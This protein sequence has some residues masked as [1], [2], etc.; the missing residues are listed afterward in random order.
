MNIDVAPDAESL[1]F[2]LLG[3]IYLLP[4]GGGKAIG[5]TAGHAWDQAPIFSPEGEFVYFVSDREGHKN[6]WRISL[7]DRSITQV[8][9]ADADVLGSLN[10]SQDGSYLIAGIGDVETRNTEVILHSIDPGTGHLTPLFGVNGS[11]IDMDTY[12]VMRD[13]I[14][15]YSGIQAKSDEIY[16]D[17]AK[18]HPELHRTK[19]Q[20]YKLDTETLH[21]HSITPAD[22]SYNEFNPQL[23][24]DGELLAYFRQYGDRKTELRVSSLKGRGSDLLLQ[25]SDADDAD[26]GGSSGTLPNYTFTPDDRNIIFSH[27]GKIHQL[28]LADMT[29]KIIPFRVTVVREVWQRVQP[30]ARRVEEFTEAKIVRWPS[31]SRDRQTAVFATI[32]YVWKMDVRT[33]EISRLTDSTDIEYMPAPSPDGRSVAFVSFAQSGGDYG[34][35]RLMIVDIND[36][37]VREISAGEKETFLLPSWSVDGQNIALIREMQTD[38]GIEAVF[39]WLSTATGD[40]HAVAKAPASSEPLSKY[41]FSRFVGF[42]ESGK[43]LFHSFPTSRKR[44]VLSIADLDG[45]NRQILAIGAPDVGGITPAPDL[46]HLA[47]TRRD[48]SIWVIPFAAGDKPIQVSSSSANARRVSEGAGYYIDWV[49]A[50]Q[51]TYGFGQRLYR[52]DVAEGA[53]KVRSFDV[54]FETSDAAE[55][56]AFKGAR[57]ISMSGDAGAGS[58]IEFGVIVMKGQRITAIGPQDEVAISDDALVVDSYGKTI[59]PGL[60]D[61]HYHSLGGRGAGHSALKLP[62]SGFS[63]PSAIAY[64]I[65]TAWDAGGAPNDGVPATAELQLA[66]R[67]SGPRWSYA[68][69]GGVGYPFDRLTSFGVALTAV[70]Q[71]QSLGATVLKEYNTPTRK[72][73]QWLSAAAR[74]SRVGI[75]SHIDRFDSMMTRIVDGYT[76]GDHP[77]IPA[78]LYKDV[79]ELLKQTGYIWT[80]NIVITQGSV[81]TDADKNSYYWREVLKKRPTE[82]ERLKA[83]TGLGR[84]IAEPRAPFKLHR[85]SRVAKAAADAAKSGVHIGVS[86]HNMPGVELHKEMWYLW[87]GGMPIED[88]LR[89][90]TIG[91]AE[92][93]GLETEIGSLEPGKIADFLVLDE[94]PL[95]DILNTLSLKYT[96]QGGVVYDSA[97]A[98][99]VDVSSLAEHPTDATVH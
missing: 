97:T 59:L 43:R 30:A 99:R 51:I 72:Q 62:D 78:P 37:K 27:G 38:T 92:K 34:P 12:E 48:G 33:G 67:I 94:N 66:G 57:L 42:D 46:K 79:H 44:T 55:S 75:V 17:E 54:R 68:T 1:V 8:T 14:V 13:R 15:T 39:G 96:V 81:G 16:F 47:L 35:G 65:T 21:R 77:Y 71:S 11:W 4:I 24:H 64:G 9:M 90:T 76:G 25:L 36:G 50:D 19:V 22:A 84:D 58:I 85:V 63:D 56:I 26:Y 6:V 28:D 40:F 73:R 95:D 18:Y 86:A 49:G 89:A 32:G 88:V 20:I 87:K 7:S 93:L 5:L 70:E 74:Q 69:M 61:T 2:D 23:S 45:G 60:L 31:I 98:R 80:P 3:D 41:I 83:I 29:S 91:N 53:L 52:Y 82:L 10:W